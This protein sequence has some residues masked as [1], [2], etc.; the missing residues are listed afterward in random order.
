[1]CNRTRFA[2]YDI[3]PMA[4]LSLLGRDGRPDR[5]IALPA[6]T[7]TVGGPGSTV[8]LSELGAGALRFVVPD[9]AAGEHVVERPSGS[10]ELRVDARSGERFVLEDGALLEWAGLR[11][12]F[13]A[14]AALDEV[15]LAPAPSPAWERLKAGVLVDMGR[16]HKATAKRWQEA[17]A[18]GT[19]DPTAA[20]REILAASGVPDD[21]PALVERCSRLG[22]DFLMQPTLRGARGAARATRKAGRNLFAYVLAQSMVV[23]LFAVLFA[24]GLLVARYEGVELDGLLDAVLDFVLRRE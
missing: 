12:R 8:E 7:I 23:L 17:V 21:D 20:A 9:D 14:E 10:A 4:S 5:S 22:R 19:W 18:A 3:S 6:G 2:G 13:D 15:A 1:M 11:L 16:A 24:I